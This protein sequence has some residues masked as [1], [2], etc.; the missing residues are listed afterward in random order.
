MLDQLKALW[1]REPIRV[2][3][4]A[5][6]VAYMVY[7]QVRAGVGWEEIMQAVFVLISAELARTQVTPVKD[8]RL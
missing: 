3:Y 8:P 6:I 1:V 7:T 2:I 5:V 4:I